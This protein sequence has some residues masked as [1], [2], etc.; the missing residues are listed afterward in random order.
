MIALMNLTAQDQP[1]PTPASDNPLAGLNL[2]NSS[3][4][5][6]SPF[7]AKFATHLVVLDDGTLK[8]ADATTLT[9]VKYWAFYFSAS[10]CP[11]CRI[12]TPK[13]VDFY[14]DFKKTHP[15]YELIF[16]SHDPSGEAM[17]AYMKAD[18]MPWPAVRFSAIDSTNL[19]ALDAPVDETGQPGPGGLPDLVLTDASGKV[20]SDSF[21]GETYV[22]PQ[23]V[24]DDIKKMVPAA[25]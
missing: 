16:V 2:D 23:R 9:S 7:V 8:P 22:G 13:L 20:L 18:S 6:L 21:H 25:N 17:K 4:S 19:D 1:K 24:L 12:F 11:P 10:W 5:S 14:N 3:G 15:N